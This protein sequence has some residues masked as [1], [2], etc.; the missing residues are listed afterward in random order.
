MDHYDH[1]S[2]VT[3]NLYFGK[4]PCD[5]VIKVL[6]GLEI[7]IILNLTEKSEDL[8]QYVIGC[9]VINF[10]I[11]DRK[12]SEFNNTINLINNIAER[13]HQDKKIY[14]HCKGGHGRSGLI[15]GGIY[16]CLYK[17]SYENTLEVLKIAH[18]NRKI[19]KDRMRKIGCP[20]T[21]LQK[22]QLMKIVNYF[23]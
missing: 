11:V 19:M 15:V 10:P 12:A 18:N 23:K 17:E 6:K 22:I 14:V 1:I 2:K 9:E 5:E 21:R 4:Y 7:D 20:Q 3:D 16:A 8:P 13:I